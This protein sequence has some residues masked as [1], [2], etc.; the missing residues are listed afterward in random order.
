MP[1]KVIIIVFDEKRKQEYPEKNLSEQR[2]NNLNPH[3]EMDLS[4]RKLNQLNY[5]IKAVDL[6][7]FEG[8]YNKK[9]EPLYL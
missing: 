3:T 9:A 4:L 2:T 6:I 8:P 5:C 7:T 1:D